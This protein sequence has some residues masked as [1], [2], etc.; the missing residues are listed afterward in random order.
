MEGS[1]DSGVLVTAEDVRR[2]WDWRKG[3]KRT[4][5]AEDVLKIVRL[6]LAE[7]VADAWTD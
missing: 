3:L 4:S 5:K 1:G 2:E 6:Q 7:R